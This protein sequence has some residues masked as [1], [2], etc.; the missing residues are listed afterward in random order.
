[1]SDRNE[2]MIERLFEDVWNGKRPETARELVHA[3]YVIHDRDLAETTRGPEL[4]T[5]LVSAMSSVFSDV[6]FTI[7]DLIATGD[8]VALRWTMTGTHTGELYG[9]PPT[10]ERVT[11]DALEI[12]RLTDGKLVETWTQSDER[13]L[14][15]QIGALPGDG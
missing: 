5:S 3:E 6:A 14:M 7:E 15:E 1:M 9:V 13:G 8:K 10:G 4:Y 2:R 11:V 12:D